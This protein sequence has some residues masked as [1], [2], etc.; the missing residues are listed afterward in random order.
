MMAMIYQHNTIESICLQAPNQPLTLAEEM[1]PRMLRR[2]AAISGNQG[3]MEQKR[4]RERMAM[5]VVVLTAKEI[6][7]PTPP[8]PRPTWSCC[9]TRTA[10]TSMTRPGCRSSTVWPRPMSAVTAATLTRSTW[11]SSCASRARARRVV[12][13]H[14]AA[15]LPHVRQRHGTKAF[16][17][18]A[19]RGGLTVS[20]ESGGHSRQGLPCA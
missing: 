8:P 16:D 5:P 11:P 13:V 6:Q 12:P 20:L 15:P 17:L 7:A 14:H 9:N 19:T 18:T 4:Q 1:K 10:C 2:Q 3:Q